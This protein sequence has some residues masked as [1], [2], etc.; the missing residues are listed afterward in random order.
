LIVD[1][2]TVAVAAAGIMG[3]L[4]AGPI[5][6]SWKS[7]SDAERQRGQAKRLV[8][9][10]LAEVSV[11][12]GAVADTGRWP[13]IEPDERFL[14]HRM[15]DRYC[16]ILAD[17]KAMR[18]SHYWRIWGVY[19]WVASFSTA[20]KNRAATGVPPSDKA[21][22]AARSM[23]AE[24]LELSRL[25]GLPDEFVDDAKAR[26]GSDGGAQPAEPDAVS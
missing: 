6:E 17:P 13:D 11:S 2:T 16:E 22:T 18:K 25:L 14:G 9:G 26:G 1:W 19:G 4:L 3:T 21:L 5:T 10:E 20:A 23:Q 12:L 8:A 7:R 15:W 24:A